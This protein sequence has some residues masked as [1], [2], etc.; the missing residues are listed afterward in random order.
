MPNTNTEIVKKVNAA[1]ADNKPEIF[2]DACADNVN[3]QM[4]GEKSY[5]GKAAIKEFMN[6]MKDMEPPNFTVDN[7]FGDGDFVTSYG[8][9]TMKDKSG[10]D[11]PYAFCDIYQF[12]D[13]KIIDLRSFVVKHK[14]EGEISGKATA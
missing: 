14:I 7:T 6:S 4:A 2:L 11:T 12:R 10:K 1:F 9:M 5:K 3:W 13:G 8:D